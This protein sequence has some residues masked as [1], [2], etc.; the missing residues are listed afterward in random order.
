M[1]R[2]PLAGGELVS[3]AAA[4]NSTAETRKPRIPARIITF[5]ISF[6]FLWKEGNSIVVNFALVT[7]K[8]ALRCTFAGK[9]S[10]NPFEGTSRF[11]KRPKSRPALKGQRSWARQAGDG[12]E[13]PNCR[14]Q[15]APKA[16][17]AARGHGGLSV[18]KSLAAGS[19]ELSNRRLTTL[20]ESSSRREEALISLLLPRK[21]EPRYL[22][23][24]GRWRLS[25]C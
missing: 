22:G 18:P 25:T 6:P 24:Y 12:S 8:K 16:F 23:C 15:I 5:I 19:T 4:H 21:C 7:R 2:M 1:T 10:P 20:S 13:P 17:G 3:R 14:L 9:Q 11:Q